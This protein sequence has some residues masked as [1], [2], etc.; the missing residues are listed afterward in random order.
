MIGALRLLD[1]QGIAGLAASLIL[2]VL[3]VI[4]KGETRHFRKESARYEKLYRDG[5]VERASL[6]ADFSAASERARADDRANAARVAANQQAINRSSLDDYQARIADA[7]ARAERLRQIP[8]ADNRGSSGSAPVP[9]LS[10]AADGTHE[11]TNQDRLPDAE[12]LIATEQAIQLQ[13][14]IDWIRAQSAIDPN[15][16]SLLIDD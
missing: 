11:V 4:Q 3:L 6:I 14:L 10:L 8:S 13:S 12:R 9:N 5:E 16:D 7:R 15:R 1:V 2:A